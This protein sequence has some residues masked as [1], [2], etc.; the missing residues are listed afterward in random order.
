MRNYV[1]IRQLI[2]ELMKCYFQASAGDSCLLFMNQGMTNSVHCVLRVC[3]FILV[4]T[5]NFMHPMHLC[6]SFS[7]LHIAFC[8][9]SVHGFSCFFTAHH[10]NC[11][12]LWNIFH[13]KDR[14]IPY[15]TLHQIVLQ[16]FHL[17]MDVGF[18][19]HTRCSSLWQS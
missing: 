8:Q 9:L 18:C 12:V 3:Q 15:T 2:Q 10:K 19:E 6:T 11:F 16:V 7:P 5:K 17:E 14:K 4:Y 13:I 1:Y